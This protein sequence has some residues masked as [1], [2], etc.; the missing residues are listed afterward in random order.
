MVVICFLMDAEALFALT[1]KQ[2]K[3]VIILMK[4]PSFF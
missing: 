2:K 1:G 4:I 3:A